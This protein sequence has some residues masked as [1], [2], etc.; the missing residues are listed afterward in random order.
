MAACELLG[1]KDGP[2]QR[3]GTIPNTCQLMIRLRSGF[4]ATISPSL[5]STR[6]SVSSSQRPIF[7]VSAVTGRVSVMFD[8]VTRPGSCQEKPLLPPSA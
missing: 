1:S 4:S 6:R 7:A 8:Q 2:C 5:G 3:T